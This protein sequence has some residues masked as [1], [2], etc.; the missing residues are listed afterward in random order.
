MRPLD[1]L[2]NSADDAWPLVLDWRAKADVPVDLL[3]CTPEA[4]RATLLALQVTTRSP[5]GA[6]ALRTGGLLV[7]DGWLR[8]LGAPSLVIGD[9]IGEWNASLG[10]TPL[11]PPLDGALVVAYDALGGFFAIN[12]G[13]WDANPGTAHY[14]APDTYGWEPLGFGYSDFVAWAMSS[15]LATFYDGMR[16]DGWRRELAGCGPDHAISVYPP[17]GFEDIAIGERSRRPVP[18][19]ELW[20]VHHD[21]GRQ[22]QGLPSGATVTLELK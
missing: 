5:M 19:R 11:D 20:T 1:E 22:L 2:I 8:I 14:L 18:A 15:Q 21:L 9:G 13:R 3:P 16:W 12:G 7:D 17:L 4:G 6:I 10:G